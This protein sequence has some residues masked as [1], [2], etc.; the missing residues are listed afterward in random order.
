[1]RSLLVTI[2]SLS[3]TILAWGVY[4]P[5]LSWGQADM[6]TTAG[7]LARLRPLVC[8]G[9]AYVGVAAVVPAVLLKL[10]GETGTWTIKGLS[11]SLAAGVCAVLGAVGMILTFHFG[12][13]AVSVMPLVFGGTAVVQALLTNTSGRHL[14]EVGSL[15]LAGLMMVLLQLQRHLL[16]LGGGNGSSGGHLGHPHGISSR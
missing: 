16:E 2:T 6:S 1:M 5:V 7:S 8:M 11:Y 4:G 3:V 15:F 13:N 10:R 12:G 9:L 14:K